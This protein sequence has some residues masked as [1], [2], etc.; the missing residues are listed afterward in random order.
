MPKV[1][2]ELF[3]RAKAALEALPPCDW[4][5]EQLDMFTTLL[6]AIAGTERPVDTVGNVV[7]LA[8]IGRI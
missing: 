2:G 7:Y 4:T 1:R 5:T 3:V 6:E 8:D